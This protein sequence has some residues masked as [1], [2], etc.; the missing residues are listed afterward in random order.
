MNSLLATFLWLFISS[1]IVQSSEKKDSQLRSI[2]CLA[3]LDDQYKS[4]DDWI[5]CGPVK[6]RLSPDQS[7]QCTT[8]ASNEQILE[9]RRKS[10]TPPPVSILIAERIFDDKKKTPSPIITHEH[11][12]KTPE[13][14]SDQLTTDTIDL[15]KLPS[16]NKVFYSL[17]TKP[18]SVG[19]FKR[20]SSQSKRETHTSERVSPLE[21]LSS[22]DTP[23]VYPF[24][25]SNKYGLRQ[26]CTKQPGLACTSDNEDSSSEESDHAEPATLG[27]LLYSVFIGT[28]NPKNPRY[29][30]NK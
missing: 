15:Q 21:P 29:K 10:I 18:Y 26:I 14:T 23:L 16:E 24:D 4:D 9:E 27:S 1:D 6:N 20:L 8:I 30:K 28:P 25:Y 7:T 2:K 19:R 3:I 12:S 5:D 17:S 11:V 22:Q 13:Q